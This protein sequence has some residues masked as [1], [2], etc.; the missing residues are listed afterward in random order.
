MVVSVGR[1][2]ELNGLE[3]SGKSLLGSHILQ[4]ETQ[5]KGGVLQY[6]Q[7]LRLQLVQTL[8]YWS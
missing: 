1:I 4:A 6:T 3:S 2:T 8:V 5:K 7:I